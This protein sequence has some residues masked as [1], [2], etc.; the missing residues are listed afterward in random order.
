MMVTAPPQA[1]ARAPFGGAPDAGG[2]SCGFTQAGNLS[3]VC[4]RGSGRS[5]L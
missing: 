1:A 3:Q 2:R 5:G 4:G